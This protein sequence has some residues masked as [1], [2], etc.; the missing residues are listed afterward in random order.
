ME[1]YPRG[2]AKIDLNAILENVQQIKKNLNPDTRIM[3]VI[4]SDGYGHGAIPIA[5]ELE[6][7][8]AV[9]SYAVATA[10]EAFSLRGA[11]IKKPILILGYTFPIHY[12]Q[13]ALQDIELTVFRTDTLA[14]LSEVMNKINTERKEEGL[15]GSKIK[16]HIKVDTGMSRIGITPDEEGLNFLKKALETEGILV[17]GIFT[18][19][20]RADEAEKTSARAQLK[21]F[22]DFV[23]GAEAKTGYRIPK[24]HIANSA[25]IIELREADMEL[26][27]AGIILYGLWPSKEVVRD[28]VSLRPA[29]EFKST[30]V[31]VKE[32]EAGTPVSYGGT[33][34]AETRIKI[35][36]IP[37]GYADGYPRSLSN[38]GE[39]L[40]RGKRAR[41]LGRVC[42]DQFMVDVTSIDGVIPGDCVTLVGRDGREQITMEEAGDSSGRFN[43][44]FAC[45]ITKR[46]PRVYRKD[47]EVLETKD[48]FM[49]F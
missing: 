23:A 1:K 22:Q 26:V 13:L 37:L 32:I 46:I 11:G 16:I 8:E 49:D 29:M 35:A 41:I 14:E 17:E 24:H 44:E 12:V 33:Y 38:K 34:I 19:F 25:G 10:E 2:Y 18:H 7:V 28:I 42:M 45:C 39:V 40:I 31:H 5:R 20:A 36:T 43:Y 6:Q 48:Y 21:C 4:K 9:E 3:A 47:K 27:R 15:P 30:V